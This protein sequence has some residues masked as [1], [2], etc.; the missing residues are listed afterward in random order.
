MPRSS[1]IQPVFADLFLFSILF[2]YPPSYLFS[3]ISVCR[4]LLPIFIHFLPCFLSHTHTTYFVVRPCPASF[5]NCRLLTRPIHDSC[6]R[7]SARAS[8]LA[9]FG[10]VVFSAKSFFSPCFYPPS[11]VFVFPAFFLA[12]FFLLCFC[13]PRHAQVFACGVF[14]SANF[15]FTSAFFPPSLL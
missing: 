13:S 3:R 9:I 1:E 15:I 8:A 4:T 6:S 10:E 14:A 11:F 7:R 2:F 5:I 12:V